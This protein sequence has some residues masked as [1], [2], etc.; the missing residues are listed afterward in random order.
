[1]SVYFVN[2][3]QGR[4]LDQVRPPDRFTVLLRHLLD[5]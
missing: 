2:F 5:L 1:M 3:I 4:N